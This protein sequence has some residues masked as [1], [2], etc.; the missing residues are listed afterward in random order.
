[1]AFNWLCACKIKAVIVRDCR[2]GQKSH[3]KII[4]GDE[5]IIGA[6]FSAIAM[7]KMFYQ[8]LSFLYEYNH[9]KKHDLSENVVVFENVSFNMSIGTKMALYGRN[10][11]V[12]ENIWNLQLKELPPI[13]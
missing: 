1:M 3:R 7:R 10:G 11:S 6:V 2:N 5:I 4:F 8:N 9:S 12:F 13:I